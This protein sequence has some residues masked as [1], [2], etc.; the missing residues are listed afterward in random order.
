MGV[1]ILKNVKIAEG[2]II[3][4]SAI[5]TKSFDKPNCAIAG[6]PAAVVKEKVEWARSDYD[7]VD[8]EN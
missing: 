2:C 3:G 5:V 7:Y 4:R 1:V 8:N 6:N